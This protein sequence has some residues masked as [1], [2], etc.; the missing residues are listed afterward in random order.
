[1]YS[2]GESKCVKSHAEG[3]LG[4]GACRVKGRMMREMEWDLRF[5]GCFVV[6]FPGKWWGGGR[7][8]GIFRH[9]SGCVGFRRGQLEWGS[10]E[11]STF[12][13]IFR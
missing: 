7:N 10:G 8:C 5:E 1:L 9:F 13:N 12:L 4:V 2:G 11:F 3:V 6:I